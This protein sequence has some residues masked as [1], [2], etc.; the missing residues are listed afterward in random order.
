MSA[1]RVAILAGGVAILGGRGTIDV[2]H[3]ISVAILAGLGIN[4]VSLGL[5]VAFGSLRVVILHGVSLI[6]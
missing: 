6:I 2:S 4:D 5:G 1:Y 3:A